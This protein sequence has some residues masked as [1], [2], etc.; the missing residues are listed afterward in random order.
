[1]SG[2]EHEGTVPF[3]PAEHVTK[4]TV[5]CV[6]EVRLGWFREVF[7]PRIEAEVWLDGFGGFWWGFLRFGRDYLG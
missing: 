3:V 5:P 4:V 7:G 2:L 6:P 1:M